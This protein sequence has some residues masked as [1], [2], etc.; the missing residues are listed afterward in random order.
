MQI[1]LKVIKDGKLS[2]HGIGLFCVVRDE[3][4]FLPFFLEHYRRIGIKHFLFYDD[5]SSDGSRELLET[6]QDCAV[7]TSEI[8]FGA[9]V[10]KTTS[11][12]SR[13][14]SDCSQ[15]GIWRS[16]G[17]HGRCR[18]VS[19]VAGTLHRSQSPLHR[20]RARGRQFS[21]GGDG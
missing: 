16:L 18:R 13:S 1:D 17:Y 19:A 11:I 12:L 5:G 3:I 8:P 6:E 15:W 4:Y 20:D 14:E 2:R 7:V 9:V 21:S 10:T